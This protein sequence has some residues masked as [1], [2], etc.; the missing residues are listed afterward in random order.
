MPPNKITH[1]YDVAKEGVL[2]DAVDRAYN[3]C[4]LKR[5]LQFLY[6]ELASEIVCQIRDDRE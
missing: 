2:C 1:K 5:D 4:I 3:D 6:P